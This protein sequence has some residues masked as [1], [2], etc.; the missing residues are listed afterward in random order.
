LPK[1][2]RREHLEENLEIFDFEISDTHMAELN[3]LNEHYSSLG[4]LQYV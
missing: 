1:A 3:A 4:S 2:N